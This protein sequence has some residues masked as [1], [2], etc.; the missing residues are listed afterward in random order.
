VTPADDGHVPARQR[1][2]RD[3]NLGLALR[4]VAAS[5]EPVSRADIAAQTGLTRSTTST[6]V[7]ALVAGGLVLELGPGARSGAGRPATGLVVDPGGAAGMGLEVGVDYLAGCIVDLAGRVR[8]REVVVGDQRG[9]TP[10]AALADLAGLAG[11]ALASAGATGLPV[12]G[13]AVAVPGLVESPDGLLRLAPNLGW[14]DVDVLGLLRAHPGLDDLPLTL[15][16]E[17]NLAALGELHTGGAGGAQSFVQLSGEIGVGAGIVLGGRLFRG[18]H[19]WGGEIGHLA[20]APDGPPCG[21]GSRGCLEQLAGQEAILRAAG[22]STQ[23]GT[24]MAGRAG[25]DEILALARDGRP[26]MLGALAQA[27]CA[28]GVAV[29]GVVNLLDVGTVV[30]GGLYAA[31]SP[32]IAPLVEQEIAGRVLSH[33]WSPV[34]V[35]VSGLGGDAAIR[36]GAGAVVQQVLDHPAARL[37]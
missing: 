2:L 3:H 30:L 31:L 22:L 17:A 28:L 14:Q 7:D 6:L 24:T 10:Q 27:G 21:C 29:A 25:V 15:D 11:R 16:N 32:W 36:G 37:G 5:A 20:I 8:H 35:T 4:K 26:D 23:A 13:A 12:T 9:R 33:R 34:N 18:T 1:G 19:G